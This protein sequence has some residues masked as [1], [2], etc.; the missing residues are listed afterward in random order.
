MSEVKAVLDLGVL[1]VHVHVLRLVLVALAARDPREH[2]RGLGRLPGVHHAYFFSKNFKPKYSRNDNVDINITSRK[3]KAPCSGFQRFSR[4][5]KAR[6]CVRVG[7]NINDSVGPRQSRIFSHERDV[8]GFYLSVEAFMREVLTEN[9]LESL[10][11][12]VGSVGSIS[13]VRFQFKGRC[14]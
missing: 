10:H 4:L 5:S 6:L 7:S 13:M 9:G 3:A 12:Y 1:L 11:F 14:S 8:L 2:G